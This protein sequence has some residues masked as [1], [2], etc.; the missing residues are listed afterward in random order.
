M[1]G[2][3]KT[4]LESHSVLALSGTSDCQT[5]KFAPFCWCCCSFMTYSL[6]SLHL[7]SLLGKVWWWKLLQVRI[8]SGLQTLLSIII[9]LPYIQ[10]IFHLWLSDIAVCADWETL[11]WGSALL[12]RWNFCSGWKKIKL[13]NGM[14]IKYKMKCLVVFLSVIGFFSLLNVTSIKQI[15]GGVVHVVKSGNHLCWLYA[16]L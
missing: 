14:V 11:K 12:M 6:C 9:I 8:A 2:Y 3:F 5:W 15:N 1:P 7:F 16:F 13:N 10:T 4:S